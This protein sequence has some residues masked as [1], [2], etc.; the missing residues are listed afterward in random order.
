MTFEDCAQCGGSGMQA[1]NCLRELICKSEKLKSLNLNKCHLPDDFIDDFSMQKT[2]VL[3]SVTLAGNFELNDSYP[4]VSTS[5]QTW[6]L[7]E[8]TYCI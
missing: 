4:A 3:K 7:N 2:K 8:K 5:I 6:A 1:R